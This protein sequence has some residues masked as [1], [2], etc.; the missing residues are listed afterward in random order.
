[1]GT[2]SYPGV[3]RSGHGADHPPPSSAEIENEQS[4]TSTPP[5]GTWWPLNITFTFTVKL[6]TA[7][8]ILEH[9]QMLVGAGASNDDD[10]DDDDDESA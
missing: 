3:K 1:M 5:L 6:P 9:R 2:G 7:K 10:D 8:S 4:Y